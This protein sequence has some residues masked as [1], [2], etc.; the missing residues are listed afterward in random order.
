M[1]FRFPTIND[2][3]IINDYIQEHYNSNETE[4]HAGNDVNQMNFAD[5]VKK[6]EKNRTE[7]DEEWGKSLIYLA[8]EENILVG[9]ISIRY[10]LTQKNRMLY[11]DI[12]Y[13]VRPT[14]R[15]KGYA[16]EMLNF[17][18]DICKE[19]GMKKVILGCYEDNI[20]SQKTIEKNGGRKIIEKDFYGKLANY[21]EI[22]LFEYKIEELK[23]DD[24]EESLKVIEE[25]FMKFEAPDYSEE[26]IKS[27]FKF[28]NYESLK[29]KLN[30]NMKMYVAIVNGKI[31]GVIAYRDNSHINL[32]FVIEEY[33]YNG[34][35]K[36]LYR[37]FFENC[38]NA[39]AT[40]ITVNSS[41]YAHNVYLK[42]GFIDDFEIQE[43]DGIKFYPMHKNI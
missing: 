24:L 33:Q 27:F 34:I 7:P 4:I 2:E 43:V 18:L 39:G 14:E 32:L 21:Y 36:A 8:F 12:G 42:F 29:E 28:A 40:K 30:D 1:N 16:T 26:G 25:T 23:L 22:K 17:A 3:S 37:L 19:K 5:W 11:G 31:V 15:K 9:M 35:A 38:K 10:E 20:A 6:I 41:P 13:G